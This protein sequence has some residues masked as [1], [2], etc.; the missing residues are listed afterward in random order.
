[1]SGERHICESSRTD[2]TKY[3]F[4]HLFLEPRL[5]KLMEEL[6]NAEHGQGDPTISLGLDN[7]NDLDLQTWNASIM[8]QHGQ[9]DGKFLML[10]IVC[11]ENYPTQPPVVK[12]ISKINI[13]CVSSNGTVDV[14]RSIPWNGATMGMKEILSAIKT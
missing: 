4:L 14:G 10:H 8:G 1:M 11:G 12:F 13:P 2:L 7:P 5:F 3:I 6:E 9:F